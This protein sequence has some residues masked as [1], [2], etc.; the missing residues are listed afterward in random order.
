[1]HLQQIIANLYNEWMPIIG[2]GT[3]RD[4]N[5]AITLEQTQEDYVTIERSVL[6]LIAK[7][8]GLD[9]CIV[10]QTQIEHDGK[11]YDKIQLEWSDKSTNG[12]ILEN[13]YFDITACQ[14]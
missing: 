6:R 8:H 4:F 2:Y 10:N 11:V 5:D 12:V 3:G 13:Y 1:M 7:M 9:H 14:H